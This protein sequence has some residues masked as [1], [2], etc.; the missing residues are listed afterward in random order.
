MGDVLSTCV[1][2]NEW[3]D[4]VGGLECC[5]G[6]HDHHQPAE[7]AQNQGRACSSLSLFH[8]CNVATKIDPWNIKAV[9]ERYIWAYKYLAQIELLLKGS[10][11]KI[12]V[13]RFLK[14]VLRLKTVRKAHDMV[15]YQWWYS[16]A[17]SFIGFR[18]HYFLWCVVLPPPPCTPLTETDRERYLSPW[19]PSKCLESHPHSLSGCPGSF[20]VPSDP[21]EVTNRCITQQYTVCHNSAD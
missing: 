10:R 5:G 12:P 3:K 13:I 19:R 16:S 18:I 20:W 7:P 11:C 17:L 4:G 1:C 9:M 15:Q 21:S 8:I 14:I 2:V 6:S